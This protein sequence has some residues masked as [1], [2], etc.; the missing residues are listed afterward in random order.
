[1]HQ[2]SIQSADG[3]VNAYPMIEAKG[4]GATP[5]L[6]TG[7]NQLIQVA[8]PGM[9]DQ[10]AGKAN[11]AANNNSS[12]VTPVSGEAHDEEAWRSNAGNGD[13]F[14]M[15]D[16]NDV[17]DSG[18]FPRGAPRPKRYRNQK[19]KLSNSMAQKRYRERK[20]RAFS[21]MRQVIDNLTTEVE[22]L[23]M[24]KNENERLRQTTGALQDLIKS[25]Q[26][27]IETLRGRIKPEPHAL[28]EGTAAVRE[29]GT[30]VG[31]DLDI[32]M[33]SSPPGSEPAVG[34]CQD[35]NGNFPGDSDASGN[36]RKTLVM[37]ASDSIDRGKCSDGSSNQQPLSSQGLPTGLS[38][39]TSQ[40]LGPMVSD[41][42]VSAIQ[43]EW[44]THMLAMEQVLAANQL[45]GLPNGP[46]S[47][48]ALQ[49]LSRMVSNLYSLNLRLMTARMGQILEANRQNTTRICRIFSGLA[50]CKD[51]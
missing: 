7:P 10:A 9:A 16:E 25:Q 12:S 41:G 11:G 19:Q 38:T 28:P 26:D 20:K 2:L 22:S 17:E 27:Q 32:V 42:T 45:Q 49:L 3:R 23:R 48:E 1:M 13:D 8:I 30:T 35:K 50:G 6:V 4:P 31:Q 44:N 34:R 37:E 21:D 47:E 33:I 18:T 5:V 24:V 29:D 40:L 14:R 15:D 46:I 43:N 39:V 36:T 51:E